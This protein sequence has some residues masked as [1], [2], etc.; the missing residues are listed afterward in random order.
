MIIPEELDKIRKIVEDVIMSSNIPFYKLPEFYIGSLLGI[1]SIFF[2]IKSFMEAKKAKEASYKAAQSVKRQSMIIEVLEISRICVLEP[3]MNYYEA[4][5]NF[6]QIISRIKYVSG[7][8]NDDTS[9]D[10]RKILT[11]IESN[12]EKIR[13]TLNDNNPVLMP[14][15]TNIPNQIYYSIEPLFSTVVGNLGILKGILEKKLIIT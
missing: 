5:N 3:N 4:S 6:N 14:Q 7:F 1:V 13:T 10:L 2:S 15:Q 9:A 11:D 8:Y 12:L